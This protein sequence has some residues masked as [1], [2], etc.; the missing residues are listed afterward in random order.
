MERRDGAFSAL[1]AIAQAYNRLNGSTGDTAI[2]S[3]WKRYPRQPRV[4]V[5][6]A[7]GAGRIGGASGDRLHPAEPGT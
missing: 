3:L 6:S 5:R 2:F 7:S 4:D 1:Y